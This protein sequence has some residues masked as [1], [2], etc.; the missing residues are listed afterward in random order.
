MIIQQKST[1][2]DSFLLK[3]V[4]H[5]FDSKP[6][7]L[8]LKMFGLWNHE[9]NEF[10]TRSKKSH[11][12]HHFSLPIHLERIPILVPIGKSHGTANSIRRPR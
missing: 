10:D 9:V 7:R 4:C 11:T 6:L 8:V 12:V 2:L 1:F 5:H 3:V